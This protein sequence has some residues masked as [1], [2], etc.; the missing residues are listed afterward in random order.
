LSERKPNPYRIYT[1]ELDR[2]G[3]VVNELY[4]S[5]FSRRGIYG[6]K[7]KKIHYSVERL[8]STGDAER[9]KRSEKQKC[10]R[11]GRA[12]SPNSKHHIL[13]MGPLHSEVS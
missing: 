5:R 7:N 12:G 6:K 8:V 13:S 9:K 1:S 11:K 2:H 10:G 4:Y 3:Y